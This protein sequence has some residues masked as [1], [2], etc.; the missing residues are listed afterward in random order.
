[1]RLL[2]KTNR[3]YLLFT[4]L[5]L[6]LAGGFLYV[7]ITD[8]VEEE[9]S[10]Q[11]L[12]NEKRIATAL[13][14]GQQITVLPPV[15][16]VEELRGR[17]EER[18]TL[19]DTVLFDALEGEIETF[20]Q[21]TSVREVNGSTYRIVLRQMVVE[22]VKSLATIGVSLAAVLL[23]L[24]LF[25]ALMNRI[26]YHKLWSPF[27]G[28][29]KALKNFSV[30]QNSP[31]QLESGGI[32]EFA[33]LN[34]AISKLTE[35]TRSDFRALKEF[36]ENASHEMQTPLAVIQAKLDE[37]LQDVAL[38]EQQASRIQ[39]ASSSVQK[40][41]RLNQTLL[42]LTKIENRQFIYTEAVDVSAMIVRQLQ[43][44]V[45]FIQDKA[46]HVDFVPTPAL[47]VTANPALAEALVSN[48]LR[49]AVKHNIPD[50]FIFIKLTD[51]SL[52]VSNSG[53]PLP[54]APA[55][56]FERFQK[57]DPSSNSLGLG[58]AIVRT[59]CNLY[60]WHV[61]YETNQNTHTLQV[62]FQPSQY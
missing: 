30:Y 20:R 1:M 53:T 44:F 29:L 62:D 33:E 14:A 16:E 52:K 38:N 60:G 23:T 39:V 51:S 3:V 26:I 55:M 59:I 19:K 5:L 42:L 43:D 40:L 57:A 8:T 7:L 54:H 24:F 50:G 2:Q 12:S 18:L 36:S 9:A 31:L 28:S 13:K 47:I 37:L 56:L 21:V 11:L 35:K 25:L 15:I 22:R 6:L 34:R 45:D 46:I 10:E 27:Y 41:S 48:L 32:T 61:T 49:N 58:L 17:R 4:A